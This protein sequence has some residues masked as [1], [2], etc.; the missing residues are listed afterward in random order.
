MSAAPDAVNTNLRPRSGWA[1]VYATGPL[2]ALCVVLGW[3]AVYLAGAGRR[4]AAIITA[5]ATTLLALLTL[6]RGRIL[7]ERQKEAYRTAYLA[8][9]ARNR[10]LDRL[11]ELAASLLSGTDLEVLFHEIARAAADL[12]EADAGIITLIVE[13]GRFLRIAAASG[14]L[15]PLSGSLLPVDRSLSGWV[16]THDEPLISDDMEIDPRSFRPEQQTEPLRDAAIIPLR[17]AEVVIGTVS[18]HNRRDGRPFGPHDLQLLRALG[19][20]AVMGLDR[21]AVLEESRASE[22]AL[23]AK[24]RELQRATQL[25]SEFLANMSHELRTPLNAII[26]FSDLMLTEGAGPVNE[27][28]RDFLEAVLR[29]GRHLLSLISSILDLSKIEAGRMTLELAQTDLRATLLAAV[30]DTESLRSA[31]QQ[32][33]LVQ[34]SE[35]P[36]TIVADGQRIRQ[37]LFNLLANASKFTPEGGRIT[38]SAVSTRAPLPVP[39][40]RSGEEARLVSRHAAWVSVI[41]T[42]IGIREEDKEKLFRE[43]SQVDASASR[44]AQGTGLGLALSRQFVEMHGGIIGADSIP[45]TGSTFWFI[46]PVEGPVRRTGHT[47]S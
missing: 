34:I 47:P 21:A 30:T 14:I 6:R 10:E 27:Q 36:I 22:R 41:D 15:A 40:E 43:F 42:G 23:V 13:E 5:G 4:D 32:E 46:L 18:V 45:G 29:N 9:S 26:G 16:V 2:I 25:K 11:R 19:D 1:R 20:Q 33:C 38:V 31:K 17:S 7:A 37:I 24:N 44:R 8:A 3:L 39:A 12:L 35:E 28:Q